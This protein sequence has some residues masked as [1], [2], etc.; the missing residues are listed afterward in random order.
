MLV[1]KIGMKE[2]QKGGRVEKG[3]RKREKRR[4]EKRKA[5]GLNLW[6]LEMFLELFLNMKGHWCIFLTMV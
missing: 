4:E 3:R 6:P 5:L 2:R 1:Q